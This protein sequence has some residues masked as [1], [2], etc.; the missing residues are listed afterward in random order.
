MTFWFPKLRSLKPRKGHLSVQTRSR[1]EE[2]GR[3]FFFAA[4]H[5][6]KTTE[7]TPN[8]RTKKKT[9]NENGGKVCCDVTRGHFVPVVMNGVIYKTPINC[10][11]RITPEIDGGYGPLLGRIIPFN[12]W[13]VEEG[14]KQFMS[15]LTLGGWKNVTMVHLQVMKHPILQIAV[16]YPIQQEMSNP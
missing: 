1:L 13:L 8:S 4:R 16:K 10:P 7:K 6:R 11:K 5:Y 3:Y 12:K 9:P 15:S 14:D 2:P